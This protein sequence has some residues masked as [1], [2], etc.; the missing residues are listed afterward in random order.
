MRD[1]MEIINEYRAELRAEMEKNVSALEGCDEEKF[2]EI[3]EEGA[4]IG[5]KIEALDTLITR[6]ARENFIPITHRYESK[7]FGNMATIESMIGRPYKGAPKQVEWRLCLYAMY[8]EEKLYYC[9]MF[10]SF[11]LTVDSYLDTYKG[12]KK[13]ETVHLV[14]DK[15]K[16]LR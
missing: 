7:P 15:Y 8:D 13:I 4:Q 10:D 3:W 9:A 1:I 6:I 11:G 14:T 2:D 12:G 5:L 16:K